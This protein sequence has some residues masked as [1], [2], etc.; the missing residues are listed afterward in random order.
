MNPKELID[1][2]ASMPPQGAAATAAMRGANSAVVGILGAA[3]Y[4]PVWA[5]AVQSRHVFVLPLAG[6]LLL[7]ICKAPP[8]ITVA[9]LAVAG[10]LTHSKS[11]GAL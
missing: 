8:W 11:D 9:F 10:V 1:R 3:P 5:S 6:F 7:T 4:D 2:I